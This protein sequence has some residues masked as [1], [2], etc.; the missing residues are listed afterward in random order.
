[1]RLPLGVALAAAAA[2]HGALVPAG[3]PAFRYSGRVD[4]RGPDWPVLVW[5][6]TRVA[7][8]FR[9]PDLTL[10]FG[11]ASG[12]NF[13]DLAV[14]GRAEVVAV[15]PG[16]A[17]VLAYA[18]PLSAGLHHL[19]LVKRS[20]AAA[21][22][23]AFGGI[24]VRDARSVRPP[25]AGPAGPRFQFFGDSITA[26]ACNEDGPVD[27]W[28]D[29]RTHNAEQSYAALAARALGAEY[30]IVAVS[31]IGIVTGYVDATFGQVWNRLYPEAASPAAALAGWQPDVIFFNFG[32]NDASFS[33]KQGRPVPA[34]FAARYQDLVRQVRAA[35]PRAQL[36][37][38]R[39]GMG[40]GATNS[41]LIGAWTA[42]ARLLEAGDP[43]V[44]HFA[45]AHWSRQH[46]RVADDQAM[47]AELAAWL[48]RQPFFAARPPG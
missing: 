24:D 37:L 42:A 2:A 6:S 10:R 40:E 31:G 18:H 14:D 30:R 47:A 35:Y 16:P 8:D 34:D 48:R 36:V 12:Q 41:A 1:L 20:E 27:Q 26:G 29:R 13:F 45:F 7:V 11:A 9:G 19:E 25:A 32:E 46:P 3:D 4:A 5:E 39:G 22:V 17:S 43:A 21:G 28:A 33:A 44:S 23:A 38:L 15:R